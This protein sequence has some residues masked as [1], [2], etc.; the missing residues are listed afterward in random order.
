MARPMPRPAP[1]TRTVRV[2]M[3][4]PF[5]DGGRRAGR[6]ARPR[7]G[8]RVRPTTPVATSQTPAR[9]ATGN[10]GSKVST[11]AIVAVATANARPPSRPRGRTIL[12]PRARVRPPATASAA[13]IRPHAGLM[14][15]ST[16]M[17]AA[18]RGVV[19]PCSIS[20]AW[21]AAKRWITAPSTATTATAALIGSSLPRWSRITG[22]RARARSP[23]A[24][25]AKPSSATR[26]AGYHAES[27]SIECSCSVLSPSS[28]PVGWSGPLAKN[29]APPA[30]RS[31][32]PARARCGVAGAV[33]REWWRVVMRP[34]S[35]DPAPST[36]GRTRD[37]IEGSTLVRRHPGRATIST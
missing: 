7:G 14:I 36:C 15:V 19:P 22:S 23:A 9:P 17:K 2:L 37:R 32:N 8:L 29:A 10:S 5:G 13:I 33:V 20:A 28:L 24:T 21:V 16:P 18:T 3:T 6:P 11:K 26:W 27:T 1:V 12:L 31:T 25:Q 34:R 4:D 35:A 30:I